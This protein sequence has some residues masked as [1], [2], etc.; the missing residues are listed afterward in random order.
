MA[1]DVLTPAGIDALRADGGMVHIRPA[2]VDD[3]AALQDLHAR[4]SDRS[5]YL[6]FFSANRRAVPEYVA[7]L[8]RKNDRDHYTLIAVILDELVGMATFDRV[9]DDSAEFALIVDDEHHSE[10]IGTLLIEHLASVGRHLGLRRFVA[11]VLSENYAMAD[12]LHNLG[13]RATSSTEYGSTHVEFLLA[14]DE[15][16]E[17]AVDER[18]RVSDV[19]SLQPLLS[20]RSIAVI[21]ASARRQTVGHQVLG[22]II[23]GKFTG[24]LNVVNPK[25][26]SV[27]GVPSVATPLLLPEAPDLAIVAVPADQVPAVIRQCGQ[28]GARAV[29][30]L[31][32][33]FGELGE[34]GR[35]MQSVIVA[36]AREYGM[37]LV[38][39]NCVGVVN[40]DPAISLDATFGR[41]PV[42]RGRLG[43]L[44]QSGAFGLAFLS[45]AARDGLGVSQFVSV[46]NKADVSGNDLLLFWEDDPHTAV[47]GM[48]L[49]SIGE[50]ARFAHI[51]RRVSRTKPILAIKSGRSEAGRRAGQ[52]HTAAAA[53]SDVFV[54]ALFERAGVLR[55]STTQQMIDA[56]RVLA[57]QPVPA[58]RR[59]V[60]LG[61]SGGPGILAA[62]SAAD[63]G[64]H[65]VELDEATRAAVKAAV[66]SAASVQNPIDLGA[67]AAPD[68][69]AAALRAVLASGCADAI[70]TVF[71]AVAVT[72]PKAIR[73]SI[74]EVATE[75][76]IPV[77]AVE[78]GM[79][80]D[81][82][83]LDAHRALPIFSYAESAVA[84]VGD[85]AR[86]GVIRRRNA[87]APPQLDGIDVE[88]A[89]RIV[90]DALRSDHDWLDPREVD[91]LLSAF[92][93]PVCA[94]QLVSTV[95]EAVAAAHALGY[96]LV[97]K[98]TGGALHKS[99]VG[100]VRVGIRNAAELCHAYA[101]LTAI[102]SHPV[103]LQTYAGGDGREAIVGAIR[104]QNIGALVMAGTGG[105][106]A[107]VVGDRAFRLAPV[108]AAEADEIVDQ[109]KLA[110]LLDG[111]RGAA[112]VSRRALREVIVRVSMLVDAVPEITEL[113]LNPVICRT[114]DCVAVDARIRIAP[115]DTT[116]DLAARQLRS[117]PH[118]T[119]AS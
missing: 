11:E 7:G 13:F 12:V 21:G 20:P 104:D 29:L 65:L 78:V 55:M 84:A 69:V 4:A 5:I 16:L 103:L 9:D 86:Y 36:V 106:L 61:N 39:P 76:D 118:G 75:A 22:H 44:S 18:D 92:G 111:V 95:D 93:I 87:A 41:A 31:T 42:T 89:R 112:P 1:L 3:M 52:S 64:L 105:V 119:S 14:P 110:R 28:R 46:G 56:G 17:A 83:E 8:A 109:L 114:D 94:Q 48:Y 38:G 6:R 85:A 73:S 91:Q 71:T 53:T 40:S 50:A 2:T 101:D 19:A 117:V 60:V 88:R 30:L 10:G 57:D 79:P 100:G 24:S 49:E 45:A 96:P 108:S 98:I 58:G 99:D 115:A 26:R 82:V 68:E 34:Q 81:R 77:V 33:G 25:R 51:A 35:A 70:V 72:D 107:D 32:A 67:A 116:R 90:A 66:P 37:R 54:D 47:I 27:L 43:V 23:A 113:D 97:A 80:D 62:D 59:L 102:S 74:A 15:H 63:A